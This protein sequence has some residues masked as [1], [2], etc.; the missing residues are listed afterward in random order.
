MITGGVLD[1]PLPDAVV[2]QSLG[3][4]LPPPGV[5]MTGERDRAVIQALGAEHCAVVRAPLGEMEDVIEAEGQVTLDLLARTSVHDAAC[6]DA[7][8]GAR[9]RRHDEEVRDGRNAVA[10]FGARRPKLTRVGCAQ[11]AVRRQDVARL[12]RIGLVFGLLIEK[13]E[14]VGE[15]DRVSGGVVAPELAVIGRLLPA[16]QDLGVFLPRLAGGALDVSQVLASERLRM[17]ENGTVDQKGKQARKPTQTSEV[18]C[19]LLRSV[20]SGTACSGAPARAHHTPGTRAR[21]VEFAETSAQTGSTV[22]AGR[23][24]I[25]HRRVFEILQ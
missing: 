5:R 15:I 21:V 11:I 12:L 6:P 3:Q 13:T 19:G 16:R 10:I 22:S 4:L 23:P 14:Q 24:V 2:R 17:R 18:H 20:C 8:V 25:G 7:H 1:F 9:V